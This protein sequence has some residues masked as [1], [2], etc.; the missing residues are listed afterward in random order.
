MTTTLSLALRSLLSR[1]AAALSSPA[2]QRVTA[3]LTP[4]GKALAAVVASRGASGRLTLVVA[5]TD[6]EVEQLTADARFFYAGL[7]GAS[8]VEAAKAVLPFPSLQVDPYRG[9]APHFKVAAARAQALHAVATGSGRI[10]VA[11]AASLL[12]RVSAPERLLRASMELRPGTEV[13]PLA[14]ADLQ[15]GRAHV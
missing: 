12:P 11:S 9:M 5:P 10:V 6:R 1:A 2:N 13:D 8:D 3:G 14:L 4:P 7:E 15:I